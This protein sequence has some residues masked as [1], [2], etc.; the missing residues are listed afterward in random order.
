MQMIDNPFFAFA[1]LARMLELVDKQNEATWLEKRKFLHLPWDS[2]GYF[3]NKRQSKRLVLKE[4][5]HLVSKEAASFLYHKRLQAANSNSS[6][7][8]FTDKIAA[9]NLNPQAKR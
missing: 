4:F 8:S 5:N 3:G 9:E 6:N 7:K 1:L 2:K